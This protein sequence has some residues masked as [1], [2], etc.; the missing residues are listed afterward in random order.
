[1]AGQPGHPS[2]RH[3]SDVETTTAGHK[4]Q[5]HELHLRDTPIAQ[6]A[7]IAA[8]RTF[9]KRAEF[10]SVRATCE[11]PFNARYLRL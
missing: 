9:E 5:L 4:L 2:F 8:I 10:S 7:E 1:M 3:S 11:L 6:E